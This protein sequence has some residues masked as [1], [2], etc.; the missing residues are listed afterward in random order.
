MSQSGSTFN[1]ISSYISCNFGSNWCRTA[2]NFYLFYVSCFSRRSLLTVIILRDMAVPSRAVSP[3]TVSRWTRLL[4]QSSIVCQSPAASVKQRRV[5][6]DRFNVACISVTA[7]S[8]EYDIDWHTIF[9]DVNGSLGPASHSHVNSLPFCLMSCRFRSRI[10][11]SRWTRTS[12][13]SSPSS[14]SLVW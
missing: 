6:Q 3:V 11:R 13:A 1:N 8:Y 9:H 14:S 4:L 10:F 5:I 12:T 7:N 2:G